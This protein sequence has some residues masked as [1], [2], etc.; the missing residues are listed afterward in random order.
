MFATLTSAEFLPT[1]IT[2]LHLP[3]LI[4]G[5]V[6]AVLLLV[7]A[8]TSFVQIRD[9]LLTICCVSLAAAAL[10]V[11]MLI[12]SIF[13]EGEN[14]ENLIQNVQMVYDVEVVELPT[15]PIPFDLGVDATVS[16]EGKAY[17]VLLTQDKE[18]FKPTLSPV[19]SV[20]VAKLERQK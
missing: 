11:S 8:I 16:H 7:T 1:N 2:E 18:T 19:E 6:L 12:G 4:F 15:E 5:I 20:D 10:G 14:K 3:S 9:I 13:V 17:K